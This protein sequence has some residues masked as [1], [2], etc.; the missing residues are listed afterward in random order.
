MPHHV[1]TARVYAHF[2]GIGGAGMSGI[3]R[4]MHDRGIVVT[5][6]DMKE[7]RYTRALAHEG[8]LVH[9]GHTDQNLGDPGIVVVSSAIRESNPELR[10][11][12][13]RGIEIWPRA[14]M[15]AEL[16][17]GLAT[18]AVAGTH[19]KTSTSAMIATMLAGMGLDPTFAIGGEVAE[20]SSNSRCGE[21]AQYV[22]EA[23]ESDGS[24]MYLDPA[25][26]LV[27]NIEADHLDHYGSLEAVEK[28]FVEFMC[29]VDGDGCLVTCADDDRLLELAQGCASRSVTYG[30]A[31]GADVRCHTLRRHG[32]GH[33]FEVQFADGR[34]VSASIPVTGEHMVQNATGALA[35]AYSLGLDP[36]AAADALASYGG[37]R[38]RF[39][40]I[41]TVGGVTV[42]DDY[43]HHPTEVR[44]TLAAAREVGYARV[45]VVFQPHRYSRTGALSREFGAAFG[46]A[47]RV[48]L[49]DVYS[50]G[51]V[52][53]PG[54]SGRTLVDA[55]LRASPRSQ[56]A[57]MPHRAD[58]VPYLTPRLAPGDLV[59]TMGAGDVTS[60]GPEIVSALGTARGGETG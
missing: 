51:E 24:F 49:M 26:A 2:I 11:A 59:L 45:W 17:G 29:K 39:D 10:A 6:S 54:V 40:H 23:D 22:V 33:A 58:L 3:A 37:V 56:V 27:T 13:E 18:V 25:V 36:C 34:T 38:R 57:Y 41:G 35:V 15:L 1:D 43:A 30:F 14:R 16:A 44:A 20:Y 9:I 42:I 48:V 12:R 8:V 53:V 46:D 52:P 31:E 32:L 28:T 19:G 4:I 5:G 55:V 60:V 21:G 47:D 7:S 50:A